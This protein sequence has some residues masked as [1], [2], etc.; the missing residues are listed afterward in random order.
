MFYLYH[1]LIES[2]V[3]GDGAAVQTDTVAGASVQAASA[4]LLLM[5]SIKLAIT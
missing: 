5:L 1:C 3:Q 4:Y 2:K